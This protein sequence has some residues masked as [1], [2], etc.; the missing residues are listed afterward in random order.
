[1]ISIGVALSGAL[2]GCNRDALSPSQRGA[3]PRLAVDQPVA[4]GATFIP[5]PPTSASGSSADYTVA[6]VPDLTWVVVRADGGITLKQN[7]ECSSQPPNYPCP[8]TSPT[9]AFSSSAPLTWGP[10]AVWAWSGSSGGWMKMRGTGGEGNESGSAVGLVYIEQAGGIAARISV[11]EPI[12][13]WNALTGSGPASWLMA[14]GYTVSAIAIPSPFRVTESAPDSSGTVTYTAE[15]VEGL[16]FINPLSFGA[17]GWPAGAADWRFYPGDSLPDKPDHSWPGWSIPQCEHKLVCRWAPPGPGRMQ[18]GAYVETRLVYARSKPAPP[19][20]CGTTGGFRAAVSGDCVPP[21]IE[22][23]CK[24]NPVPHG[25]TVQCEANARPGGDLQVTKWWFDDGAGHIIRSTADEDSAFYWGG[26]VVVG[27]TV[28]AEGT[29]D[30]RPAPPGSTTLSVTGRD[31]RFQYPAEPAP[32][33]DR[34]DSLTYPPVH[35]YGER[36]GDGVFGKF[37]SGVVNTRTITLPLVGPNAG[38]SYYGSATIDGPL[39]IRIN[40]GLQTGDPWYRA[41]RGPT[42]TRPNGC[43]KEFVERH[44]THTPRHE[45]GHYAI[46]R[47]FWTD[48]ATAD[49]FERAVA[50]S[51]DGSAALRAQRDSL[52]R[53]L[54]ARQ[55]H[56]DSIDYGIQDCDPYPLPRR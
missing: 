37:W 48:K 32:I 28:H 26:P 27:G 40:A 5:S 38:V 33:W 6:T 31:W 12:R 11:P 52:I 35:T 39:E 53:I 36:I 17:Y 45:S 56:H 15:T 29:I 50:F 10:V 24:P 7:P 8:G 19:P 41:Q 34:G 54:K 42:P 55:A 13:A 14:G 23:L 20:V 3:V 44:A 25:A 49:A 18:V 2:G 30:G 51:P 4:L 47:D 22:V 16:Q 9:G 21:S 43:G 46:A 1:M